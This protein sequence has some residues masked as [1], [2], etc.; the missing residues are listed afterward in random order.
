MTD[1]FFIT[2][3][4]AA[5]RLLAEDPLALLLGMLLDQQVPMEWAFQAP[6][7]LKERLG[8]QLDAGKIAAMGEDA[9]VTT[10]CEKP[11]L[12][13]YPAS[14]GK[15]AHALCVA[16]TEQYDGDAAKVWSDAP[17]GAELLKRL[18]ALPGFGP[19]KAKIFTAVL[20]KRLGVQPPGWEEAA[21]PFSDEN[22]RSVADADT[23]QHL[24]EVRAWKKMMKAKGKGK[25]D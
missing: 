9:V 20:G 16:L 14:M 13:R 2:G 4:E 15:R 25:S 6:S 12:H 17:T 23:P 21:A 22:R 10:F 1:T 19:D 5:D 18:L 24:E 11:A 7:V 8:G 3:D